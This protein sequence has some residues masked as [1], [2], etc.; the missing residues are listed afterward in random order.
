MSGHTPTPWRVKHPQPKCLG[1]SRILGP[2]HPVDGGDYAPI[3][4]ADKDN[5]AFITQAANSHD[6]L[7][8]ALKACAPS[9]CQAMAPASPNYKGGKPCGVCGYCLA[10]AALKLAGE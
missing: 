1:Q 5:A 3:A 8:N 9:A 4:E 6:A 7:V 10:S 2:V